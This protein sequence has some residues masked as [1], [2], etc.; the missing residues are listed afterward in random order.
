M[1][2]EFQF[3]FK[4]AMVCFECT[5]NILYIELSKDTETL[6][7][8]G[9]AQFECLTHC[10]YSTLLKS[11]YNNVR[12]ISIL[13]YSCFHVETVWRTTLSA[14]NHASDRKCSS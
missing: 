10:P 2:G 8:G 1:H 9:L 3:E 5:M 6:G 4:C 11:I 7:L 12:L 14:V 13:T